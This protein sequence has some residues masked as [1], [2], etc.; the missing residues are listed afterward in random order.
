MSKLKILI[1]LAWNLPAIGLWGQIPANDECDGAI[2]IDT[3]FNFCTPEPYLDFGYASPSPQPGPSCNVFGPQRDLWFRFTA[4]A[5]DIAIISKALDVPLGLAVGQELSLYSGTCDNL[6]ELDCSSTQPA[7][8]SL[9]LYAHNLVVG[10]PYYIRFGAGSGFLYQLCVRN[11]DESTLNEVS[12]DCPTGTLLCS[13]NPILVNQIFGPGYDPTEIDDAPCLPNNVGELSS[14]WF[15]FTAANAGKLEFTITPNAPN[16]D[17]DFVLYRLPNG[18]GDCTDKIWERCMQAGGQDQTSPCMGPTG[19]N[20]TALDVS[21]PAGCST[22][23]DNFLRAL[24][25][26][27]DMTYALQVDNFTTPGNGFTLEWGGD[28][29]F[30]GDVSAHFNTDEPDKILCIGEELLLTD[31]SFALGSSIAQWQWDL[32]DGSIPVTSNQNGPLT[33]QYQTVGLKRIILTV[34]NADACMGMDTSFVLVEPCCALEAEVSVAPGCPYDPPSPAMATLDV[35]NALAPLTAHWSNGQSGP[36]TSTAIDSSGTYSVL[37]TDANGCQDSLIFVVN[38]P[39]NVSAMFPPDT[40]IVLG[41]TINL[42]VNA[43]P[44][45]SVVVWWIDAAGDTLTG[46]TTSLVAHWKPLPILWS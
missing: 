27:P 9:L 42:R 41:E 25:L 28:A 20:A 7:K 26:V 14:A 21:Q 24:T 5:A 8:N 45:T 10:Q 37:V 30:K 17:I 44:N 23:M 33:V 43:V 12:G 31:S 15:V 35:Q 36:N 3:P 11:E 4:I 18:P 19:L 6:T 46:P 13:K 2:V 40:T 16:D 22:G 39:L 32:G 29:L 1:F 38:T 34:S